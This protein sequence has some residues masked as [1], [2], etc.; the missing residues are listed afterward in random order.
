M[1]RTAFIA[2][3][4]FLG[5]VAKAAPPEQSYSVAAAL[6][7]IAVLSAGLSVALGKQN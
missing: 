5:A 1:R 4:A 6:A 7:V 2:G 3:L